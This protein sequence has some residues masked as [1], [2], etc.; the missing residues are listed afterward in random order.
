MSAEPEV[1]SAQAVL[2]PLGVDQRMEV[3]LK[4]PGDVA[5]K[6]IADISNPPFR[7]LLRI[8]GEGGIVEVDNPCLPHKGHSIRE[9]VGERYREF[10]LAGGT[11]YDYQLAAFIDA[12]ENG[13]PLPT[14]G[15][16]SIGNMQ[17]VD[18][19]YTASGVRRHH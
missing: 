16:D 8:E 19:I 9:W 15:L 10:T 13:H 7:G 1:I 17:V 6:M 12:V 4:F 11:T 2:T 14:G 5:A 3:D 18:A